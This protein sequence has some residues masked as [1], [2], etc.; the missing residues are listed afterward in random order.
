M[1]IKLNAIWKQGSARIEAGPVHV[2]MND[3]LIHR[4]SD[5]VRV[6]LEG[7]RLRAR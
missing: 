7:L 1:P 5:V 2:S 3:Y 6:G 4:F